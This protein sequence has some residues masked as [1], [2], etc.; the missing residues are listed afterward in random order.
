MILK[1]IINNKVKAD[2]TIYT[3]RIF[4]IKYIKL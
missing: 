3:M 4:I 2:A 1:L